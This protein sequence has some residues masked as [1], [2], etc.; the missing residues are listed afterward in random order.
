MCLWL[1]LVLTAVNSLLANFVNVRQVTG[2]L[3]G[4]CK[5]HLKGLIWVYS[6]KSVFKYK[7][8]KEERNMWQVYLE[9]GDFKKS[10]EFCRGEAAQTNLVLVRKAQALFEKEKY[11][12]II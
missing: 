11:V 8:S 9:L 4:V 3:L 10:L 5:D 7:V 2:K 6:E 1:M 12:D